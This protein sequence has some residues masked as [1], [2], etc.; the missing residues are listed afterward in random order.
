MD[1]WEIYKDAAGEWRW[2]RIAVNGRIVG[3]S[4]H[5]Y[6]NRIDCVNNAKRDEDSDRFEFYKDAS[7][8]WRWRKIAVNGRIVGASS[9]GY[10]NRIDCIDNAKRE[11][12]IEKRKI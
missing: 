6:V 4:S 10:V 8:E 7:D 11:G 5:G 2:R 3:A 12:Y 9:Q 1:R